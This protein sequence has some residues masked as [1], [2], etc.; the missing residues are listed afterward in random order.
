MQGPFS[1]LSFDFGL[2]DV[3]FLESAR[4]GDLIVEPGGQAIQG[5]AEDA[6][7]GRVDDLRRYQAGFNSMINLAM[8]PAQSVKLFERIAREMS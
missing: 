2:D 1:I 7:A 3:L 4:R 5:R 6:A 8:D